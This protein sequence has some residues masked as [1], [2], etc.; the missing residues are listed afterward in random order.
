VT[1]LLTSVAQTE[2]TLEYVAEGAVME[3][4]RSQILVA[5]PNMAGTL[6]SV[7]VIFLC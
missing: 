5:I 4:A 7:E 1:L 3:V 2:R 6:S